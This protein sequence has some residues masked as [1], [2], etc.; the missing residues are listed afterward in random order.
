M[1]TEISPAFTLS[2]GTFYQ[3]SLQY[4]QKHTE[5]RMF[6][7]ILTFCFILSIIECLENLTIICSILSLLLTDSPIHSKR[8]NESVTVQNTD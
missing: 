7:F 2:E 3:Y 4:P 6:L 1:S 8:F 5:S